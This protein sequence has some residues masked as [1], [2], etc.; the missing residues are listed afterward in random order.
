[1]T[2]LSKK[3]EGRVTGS[4]AGAI[5]GTSPF[6]TREDVIQQFLGLRKF[7]GNAATQYGSFHEEYAFADLSS[8]YG[9]GSM[10]LNSANEFFEYDTWLGATPDGFYKK[11]N[12]IIEIKCPFSLKDDEEPEFKSIFDLPHYYA[13]LQIEMHCTGMD[14]AYFFQ[15]NRFDHR[16][17]T[18]DINPHWLDENLPKLQ[19]FLVE[20]EQRKTEMGEDQLLELQ[21][22]Q[23][24][25]AFDDAKEEL[26][27]AKAELIEK[28]GGQ[29]R[30]FGSVS[31]FPRHNKGTVAYAKIVK[32]KLPDIDLDQYRGEPST[33]WIVK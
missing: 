33:T 19:E 13:Q 28:A 24:K 16:L 4:I 12:A 23:A 14:K 10:E 8:T 7:E 25:Q 31:V 30:E 2:E 17:E 5:L 26:D 15:W 6:M 3:R 20:I 21:Y 27:K 11:D 32:E 9:D 22:I 18:V 1:M 29:K